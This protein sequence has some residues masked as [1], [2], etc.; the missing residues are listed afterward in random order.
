MS[1]DIPAHQSTVS[2]GGFS[3]DGDI[4]AQISDVN[5][6]IHAHLILVAKILLLLIEFQQTH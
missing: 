2:Q 3:W 6:D 5:K 4:P 1:G